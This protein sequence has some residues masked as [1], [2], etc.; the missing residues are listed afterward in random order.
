[1]PTAS[2]LEGGEY[3]QIMQARGLSAVTILFKQPNMESKGENDL[4]V[5]AV[6]PLDLVGRYQGFHRR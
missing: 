4:R 1:M 3:L 2:N 6:V 5:V